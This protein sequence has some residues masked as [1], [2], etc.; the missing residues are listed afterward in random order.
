MTIEWPTTCPFCG[1]RHDAVTTANADDERMPED[2]DATICFTCGE[3]SIF[4]ATG[5]MR[6]PTLAELRVLDEDHRVQAARMAWQAIKDSIPS[7][8]R[9]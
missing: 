7:R 8:R 1:Q 9:R 6:R 4:D 3:F 5:G 2:G